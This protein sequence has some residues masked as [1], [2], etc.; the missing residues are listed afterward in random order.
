MK[1]LTT[2]DLSPYS[3]PG[4]AGILPAVFYGREARKKPSPP[5]RGGRRPGWVPGM[6]LRRDPP[7]RYAAPLPRGD[8]NAANLTTET[9]FELIP[10]TVA[11]G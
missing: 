1:A 4:S 2:S 3:F 5:W 7:R 11:T 10:F 8:D 6:S 9:G